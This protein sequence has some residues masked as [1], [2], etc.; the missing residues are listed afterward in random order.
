MREGRVPLEREVFFW[1]E[2]GGGN[3]PAPVGARSSISPRKNRAH[4]PGE[5]LLPKVDFGIP[6]ET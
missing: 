2:G 3:L 5:K 1:K 6:R 4:F